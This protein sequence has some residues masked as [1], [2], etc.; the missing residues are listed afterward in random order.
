MRSS[1]GF[2]EMLSVSA[3]TTSPAFTA[4]MPVTPI[5]LPAVQHRRDIEGLRAVAVL[6][7]VAYHAGFAEF[8]G[9]FI[10]VDVFFVISGFLITSLLLNE[11]I[12]NGRIDLREFYA[13]RIRRL[14]PIS[15]AV[16]AVST[17]SALFILPSTSFSSL[18][19]D[20]IAAAG[21]VVNMLFAARGTDY[22]AGDA[23]PSI[24]QHYWSLAVEEQFYLA[25]PGLLAVISLNAKRVRRRLAPIMVLVIAASFFASLTFTSSTPTW[26][27]FG[28][29][30]RAFELGIGALL[31][32]TWPSI[33]RWAPSRRAVLSW[34]GI[35]G[36]VISV[37]LASSVSEFPG[38]VAAV[39]VL[40]TAA[41]ICGGNSLRFGAV[42]IL[43]V[44]MLQW[45]GERSYSLYLW[46]WP[47]LVLT[48]A[49]VERPLTWRETALALI[50]A[51]AISALGYRFI[52]H[53]LRRSQRLTRLPTLSYARGAGL[54]VIT[55]FIGF[56]TSRYQPTLATGFIAEAPSVGTSTTT[57]V[58]R[59]TTTTNSPPTTVD[60]V[61]T[62]ELP[63]TTTL[64][65][66]IDNRDA[67]PIAAVV[68]ALKNPVLP[69]NVQPSVYDA[70]NDATSL[71]DTSCHQFMTTRVTDGCVFGDTDSKFTIGLIGDSHAAQWFAA[72]NTIA[73]DNGWRL[74]AHT[75]GGCP[76]L[77]VATWNRGAD[78]IFNHCATWRDSVIDALER[79]N[80]AAV[81]VS[82][83]WGLLEASTRQA[84]PAA[85]WER[86]LPGLFM[87]LR[88]AGMEPILFLDSPDP[89]GS[90]PA[91]AASNRND[92]TS[93]EPGLLRNTERAVRTAALSIADEMSVGLIDPHAWLCVDSDQ[94]DEADATRC[95]VVIG[96]IL[97]YRDSHH[98]S[99]TFVE[100]FTPILSSELVDWFTAQSNLS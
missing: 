70:Q 73:T 33:E 43:R 13:R 68:Q 23:D 19:T 63:T 79:E 53:P 18:G 99:N 29:H 35:I 37:P 30:T 28:L 4:L 24:F 86:D 95:P 38:W 97:V 1:Q 90:V 56:A 100:W 42:A 27:Y 72:V 93:C 47:I 89:Y 49:A 41:V 52:E 77:N 46:H 36:I 75:Q 17:M 65:A 60:V 51:F 26:S 2:G 48:A 22:L 16:L 45:V 3:A 80:V 74:I 39:P 61:S 98:L 83:H 81:I 91:C 94:N 87:R 8:A 76:L 34:L 31:A 6:V 58:A 71:Y 9:G 32:A 44:R 10:G 54:L 12:I 84:I 85:V 57:T 55:A 69:D 5:P 88:G 64:P 59:S 96:N 82:Q 92:L 40:S 67:Q 11:R 21:F 66:L 78:A 7:V 50:A 25:W 15:T 62:I 20:V 14:L